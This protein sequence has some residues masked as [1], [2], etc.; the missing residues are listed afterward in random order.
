MRVRMLRARAWQNAGRE[1]P[2]DLGACYDLPDL[3]A[4]A[5]IASGAA[6]RVA[7]AVAHERAVVR[8]PETAAR[9]RR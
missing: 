8:P 2:L 9:R 5:F 1:Q 6:E 4:M 3:I 7:V